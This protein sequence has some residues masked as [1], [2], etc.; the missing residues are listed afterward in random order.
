MR[1]RLD[2]VVILIGFGVNVAILSVVVF[3]L[4][5]TYLAP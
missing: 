2:E 5:V 4:A 1:K 3:A